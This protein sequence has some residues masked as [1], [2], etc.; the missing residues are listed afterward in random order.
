MSGDGKILSS[1]EIP[2]CASD[3][4]SRPVAQMDILLPMTDICLPLINTFT[5]YAAS[6]T[7][8]STQRRLYLTEIPR[9]S[10]QTLQKQP[11]LYAYAL[12]NLK[13]FTSQSHPTTGEQLSYQ[14]LLWPTATETPSFF[15]PFFRNL[16]AIHTPLKTLCPVEV[17]ARCI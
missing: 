16:P 12:R 15:P 5:E 13:R 1:Y 7:I 2:R 6:L 4:P 10:I 9:T 14:N 3:W 8:Q 17:T 11:I